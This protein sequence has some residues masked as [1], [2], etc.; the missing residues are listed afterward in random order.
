MHFL[1]LIKL[2]SYI[3]GLFSLAIRLFAN[4]LSGHTLLKILTSFV[5]ISFY[6]GSFF[7]FIN[8]FSLIILHVIVVIEISIGLLQAYVFFVLINIYMNDVFHLHH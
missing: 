5:F 6:S 3:S 8:I 1:F 4:M 7:F 2:L